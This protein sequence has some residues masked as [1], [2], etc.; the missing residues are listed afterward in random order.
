MHWK[1][2][3]MK[4]NIFLLQ[5]G[6]KAQLAMDFDRLPPPQPTS[7]VYWNPNCS[8]VIRNDVQEQINI[9][10]ANSKLSMHIPNSSLFIFCVN[11]GAATNSSRGTLLVA[12]SAIHTPVLLWHTWTF[13]SR[14]AGTL[15]SIPP[16]FSWRR[17]R[18]PRAARGWVGGAGAGWRRGGCLHSAAGPGSPWVRQ[19][20][21]RV[22]N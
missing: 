2:F 4:W 11:E 10:Q 14:T 7:Q 19:A 9:L 5:V 17:C 20:F 1:K 21:W 15:L 22:R 6:R 3:S 8:P 18:P 12:C 13:V 16:L